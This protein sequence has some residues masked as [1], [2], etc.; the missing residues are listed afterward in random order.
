MIYDMIDQ[1]CISRVLDTRKQNVKSFPSHKAHSVGADLR[2]LSPQL[3]TSLHCQ[4]TDT[5]RVE[6]S[7]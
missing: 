2:F 5:C 7:D 3:D 6:H 1:N 4:T